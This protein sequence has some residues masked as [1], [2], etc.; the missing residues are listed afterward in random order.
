MFSNLIYSMI[1]ELR[2]SSF[3]IKIT[4]KAKKTR[5][6]LIIRKL[7]KLYWTIKRI[8]PFKINNLI[9][10]FIIIICKIPKN[11]VT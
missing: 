8:R 10:N 6:I 4:K 5:Q 2:N 9:C 1:I 7:N 11:F 3:Q